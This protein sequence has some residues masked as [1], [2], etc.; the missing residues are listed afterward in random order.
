[1]KF[2]LIIMMCLVLLS[3][4]STKHIS[5]IPGIA[6]NDVRAV[7]LRKLLYQGI[8]KPDYNLLYFT[9]PE[10]AGNSSKQTRFLFELLNESS[11]L[12]GDLAFAYNTENI[13]PYFLYYMDA[14][15]QKNKISATDINNAFIL[16]LKVGTNNISLYLIELGADLNNIH[17]VNA[18]NNYINS[19]YDDSMYEFAKVLKEKIKFYNSNNK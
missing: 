4:E 6:H 1:M 7:A 2:K 15:M 3:C 13:M 18:I 11:Y 8:T 19:S 5:V 14:I 10:V 16:S 17:V 9:N 12:E